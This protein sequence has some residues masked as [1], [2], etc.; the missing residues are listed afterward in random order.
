M[1][2]RR[3]ASARDVAHAPRRARRRRATACK[4]PAPRRSSPQTAFPGRSF[5]MPR[6]HRGASNP[7]LAAEPRHVV[8]IDLSASACPGAP[9]EAR[10]PYARVNWPREPYPRSLALFPFTLVAYKA[11][12]SFLSRETEPFR[13]ATVAAVELGSPRLL[14]DGR[15]SPHPSYPSLES[16]APRVVTARPQPRRRRARGDRRRPVPSRELANAIPAPFLTSN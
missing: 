2:F 7:A 5:P 16:L 13:R 8:P 1:T 3:N 4:C 11:G 10:P 15:R 14:V 6:A 9:A 12:R